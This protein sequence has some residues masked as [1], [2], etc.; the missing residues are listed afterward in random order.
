MAG[1]PHPHTSAR[2]PTRCGRAMNRMILLS[3]TSSTATA[4]CS[5]VSRPT[6]TWLTRARLELGS[7]EKRSTHV[8]SVSGSAVSWLEKLQ[9]ASRSL[10][11]RLMTSTLHPC[12]NQ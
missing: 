11:L 12:S 2:L 9:A 6:T 8:T 7:A 4:P 5:P 1:P 3:A 10:V